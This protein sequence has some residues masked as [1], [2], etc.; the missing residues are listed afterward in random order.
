M[1]RQFDEQAIKLEN[2]T[3]GYSKPCVMDVKLGTQLF[4]PLD[5]NLTPD[6]QTRMEAESAKTTS[7]SHGIRLTGF[8]VGICT[9]KCPA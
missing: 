8:S 5:P 7:G 2:L 6:K 9:A 4:D 1:L 3:H